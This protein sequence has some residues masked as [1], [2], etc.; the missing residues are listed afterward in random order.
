MRNG[1][2][3]QNERWLEQLPHTT[4]RAVS[5]VALERVSFH[6]AE[7]IAKRS[8]RSTLT[9]RLLQPALAGLVTSLL[10]VGLLVIHPP[11]TIVKS[12]APVQ[13][14]LIESFVPQATSEAVASLTDQDYQSILD[15]TTLSSSSSNHVIDSFA[16]IDFT[17]DPDVAWDHLSSADRAIILKKI[18]TDSE[19]DWSGSS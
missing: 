15:D 5:H 4:P 18:A 3:E 19:L 13:A 10:V 14:D 2:E 9:E 11:K 17:F 7:R 16:S 12:D 1:T 6:V 8:N